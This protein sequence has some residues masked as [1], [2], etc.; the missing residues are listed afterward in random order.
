MVTTST[1]I[2]RLQHIEHAYGPLRVMMDTGRDDGQF[3]NV[4]LPLL[5]P[6]NPVTGERMVIAVVEV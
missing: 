6:V 4:Q 3:S 1:L 2:E 5:L